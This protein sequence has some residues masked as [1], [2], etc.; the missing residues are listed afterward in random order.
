MN[1]KVITGILVLSA[2]GLVAYLINK[3]KPKNEF[4]FDYVTETGNKQNAILVVSDEEAQIINANDEIEITIL[5]GDKTYAGKATVLS[6]TKDLKTK[7][8]F[9]TIDKPKTKSANG[10][11]K[12]IKK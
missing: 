11:I 3:P 9:I 6:A 8:Q 12:L 7:I 1:K 4:K 10:K 2:I 5:D